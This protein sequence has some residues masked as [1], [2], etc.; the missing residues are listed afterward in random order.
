MH[1]SAVLVPALLAQATTT[2]FSGRAFAKAYNVGAAVFRAVS[3][4]LPA[5]ASVKRGW[6]NTATSGR[7]AAVAALAASPPL[8]P[9]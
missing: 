2:D 8:L 9:T 6:H 4:A 7:I 5:E 3:E 1:P